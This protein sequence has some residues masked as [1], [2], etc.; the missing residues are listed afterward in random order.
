VEGID[1]LSEQLT[2]ALRAD[3]VDE[4]ERLIERARAHPQADDLYWPEVFEDLA[5][6]YGRQRRYDEA[7]AAMQRALDAGWG[8]V[9]D[10][11][12]MIAELLLR[13][14][15]REE[16]AALWAAVKRDT[17]DDVW[18]YNNA[19]LEYADHGE[20]EIAHAWLSEGLEL[21]LR[22]GD[23][24]R[25]VAQ[26]SDL[27]RR[28]LQALGREHDELERRADA[29]L[30]SAE[31]PS[32]R[33][34]T[35]EPPEADIGD[36]VAEEPTAQSVAEGL[37][38]TNVAVGWFPA[39]DYERALELWPDLRELW[40]GIEHREYCRRMQASL[41]GWALRGGPRNLVALRLD[42]YLP[43]CEAHD[44][45]PAEA[46]AAYAADMARIGR[47]QRW[48]PGRNDLCWCGSGLKYKRCCGTVSTTATHPL[49]ARV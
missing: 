27:R 10:G 13:A 23:P 6:C 24:E 36:E 14:G 44:R 29:F 22:T 48:P 3:R 45:D 20:H 32:S 25:L 4:A 30:T 21:A 33:S 18:L 47:C 9:P 19:G 41:R 8:G 28:S 31:Q 16:S 46:R 26:L 39:G 42:E 12:T 1:Q 37:A 35:R 17:P 38:G 2:A 34:S 7:I 11:R 5:L 43:W 15:R 49:H 40:E